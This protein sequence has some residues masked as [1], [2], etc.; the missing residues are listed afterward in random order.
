MNIFICG[1]CGHLE[2]GNAPESC[3]VCKSPREKYSRNDRIFEGSAEKSKEAAVKHIPAITLNSACGL[4][5][6]QTCM[7]VIVRIGATLHP[8]EAAHF[9]QFIDCYIDEKHASRIM[10]GPQ[11][12]AAGC[13]HLKT[14]GKKVTIVENCNIHGYWK[15]EMNI[16]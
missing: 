8:M 3:P 14:Q 7:D 2:F 12:F 6:E 4:I 11:V 16:K 10:L 13:F 9:I 1:M 15:S 5:P